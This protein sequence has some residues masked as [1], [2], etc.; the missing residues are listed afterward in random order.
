M[1]A[2]S[3]KPNWGNDGAKGPN[4]PKSSERIL[5]DW[6]LAG[7]NYANK[8]HEKEAKG[9]KKTHRGRDCCFD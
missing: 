9:K 5:L 8:W 3:R 6:L 1:A 2:A 4:D 7:G